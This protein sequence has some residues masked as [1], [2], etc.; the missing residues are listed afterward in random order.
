MKPILFI[1]AFVLVSILF[2]YVADKI[3]LFNTNRRFIRKLDE[4]ERRLSRININDAQRQ[5]F[6]LT[7]L[8]HDLFARIDTLRSRK[9]SD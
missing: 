8:A 1:V 7:K 9:P 2:G 4:L 3:H 5:L 6:N